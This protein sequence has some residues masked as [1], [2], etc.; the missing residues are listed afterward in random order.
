MVQIAIGGLDLAIGSLATYALLPT[1]PAT[2]YVTLAVA[3]VMAALVGFLCHAPGSLGVFEVAMLILL[4]Q[5]QK[6]ALLG[7]LLILHF[8]YLVL[9][10]AIALVLLAGRRRNSCASRPGVWGLVCRA[11]S[12]AELQGCFARSRPRCGR[13]GARAT[14][15]GRALLGSRIGPTDRLMRPKPDVVP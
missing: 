12:T 11:R 15:S 3:Y 9:P 1:A 8:L 10:L 14:S 13:S 4:P 5:Y 6:E 7:S 2:D